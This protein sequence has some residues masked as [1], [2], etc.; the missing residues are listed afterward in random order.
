ML[1]PFSELYLVKPQI[2]VLTSYTIVQKRERTSTDLHKT[3]PLFTASHQKTTTNMFHS[4]T[5][6]DLFCLLQQCV[7]SGRLSRGDATKLGE[8]YIVTSKWATVPC[9]STQFF[10]DVK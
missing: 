1:T 9:S 6:D 2:A 4:L 5:T 8:V 3:A 7:L 10:N